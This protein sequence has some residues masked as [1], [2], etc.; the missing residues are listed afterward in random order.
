MICS[1]LVVTRVYFLMGIGISDYKDHLVFGFV[2]HTFWMLNVSPKWC[3]LQIPDSQLLANLHLGILLNLWSHTSFCVA[4]CLSVPPLVVVVVVAT[5]PNGSST[6]K[7]PPKTPKISDP[8]V[9]TLARKLSCEE[10]GLDFFS[11]TFHLWPCFF[12]WGCKRFFNS[13]PVFPKGRDG[14]D[15]WDGKI[16]DWDRWIHRHW[17]SSWSKVA[18]VCCFFF[19]GRGWVGE[20]CFWEILL[21]EEIPHH[22]GCINPVN[23]KANYLWTGAGFFPS[24]V[25][26]QVGM[27]FLEE[28]VN[29]NRRVRVEEL[30]EEALG[31]WLVYLQYSQLCEFHSCS[32]LCWMS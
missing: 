26:H 20:E 11:V 25:W 30:I 16:C 23:N 27:L 1:T 5:F 10:R 2:W 24:T 9:L 6:H 29:K 19:V 18:D 22:L 12:V 31:L 28:L 3:R 14:W 17:R 15:G 21:M 32:I 13:P 7:T 8:G 4:C